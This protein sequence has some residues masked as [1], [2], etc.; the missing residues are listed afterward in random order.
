M[1]AERMCPSRWLTAISGSR[2]A[3]A[4]AFAAETPTSSDPISPGPRVTAIASIRSSDGGKL[5]HHQA[6][7]TLNE[8]VRAVGEARGANVRI[9]HLPFAP[10]WLAAVGCEVV[11]KPLGIEPPLFRRRVDWFRQVRAFDISKA[12]RDLDWSPRVG[13]DE[14]LRATADWYRAEGYL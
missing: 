14:G 11:C 8:I 9:T 4:I 2:R 1:N 6:Y 12:K 7:Y 13:L 10:I 3:Q 5:V